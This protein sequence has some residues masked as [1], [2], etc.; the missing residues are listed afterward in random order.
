MRT[1][2]LS[3]IAGFLIMSVAISSCLDSDNEKYEYSSDATIHAFGIDTIHGRYYPFTIDQLNRLIYNRDSLP[4]GSDTIIDRILIDTL[5]VTG[6]VTSGTMDT[7]FVMT[8]SVDLRPAMNNDAGMTFRVHAADGV[9]VREYRLKVNVHL[10]DPDSLVWTDMQEAGAVFSEAINDG[11]QKAVILNEAL[12]VYTSHVTAYRTSTAPDRYGWSELAVSGLPQ[13]ARLTTAVA[14][15]GRLYMLTESGAV[16]GSTD[17]AAWEAIATLG[18]NVRLLIGGF[19]DRLCG[20]VEIEGRKYFNVSLDGVRWEAAA[21]EEVP[22]GFPTENISSTQAFTGNGVEKVVLVGM[23]QAGE[24]ETVPWFSLDGK[25]WADLANTI[26]DNYCPYLTNPV[27]MYYNN[28][29]YCFGGS[30]DAI[31]SS[32]TGI[33]WEKTKKKFLLPEAFAGKGSYSVVVEPTPRD[34]TVTVAEKRNYIWVVFGG[35][36]TPNEVWRGRLNKYGF[37]IE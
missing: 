18:D 28:L 11:E 8:D 1:K 33:A 2:F 23:P 17:G 4:V 27:I 34:R 30:M 7:V 25:G 32:V 9:N 24:T 14:Y 26:Y 37:E 19:S 15:A 20:V 29:F 31:Y 12:F 10:Q 6:W 5:T 3:V 21:Y 35:E 36:G 22:A 16:Y 13:D